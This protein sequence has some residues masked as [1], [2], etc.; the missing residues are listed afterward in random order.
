MRDSNRRVHVGRGGLHAVLLTIVAGCTSLGPPLDP[1]LPG[2]PGYRGP[3]LPE[4][5]T[6]G[7]VE[8]Q[9]GRGPVV[10]G[11]LVPTGLPERAG[12]SA[13]RTDAEPLPIGWALKRRPL[14]LD[15]RS[16]ALVGGL[17]GIFGGVRT[18]DLLGREFAYGD[19]LTSAF[20]FGALGAVSG[21]LAG[22]LGDDPRG[23]FWMLETTGALRGP[24]FRPLFRGA[25]PRPGE[26]DHQSLR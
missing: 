17:A 11:S 4:A 2:S 24:A 25:L 18:R 1:T 8:D 12:E 3:D 22:S 14:V 9:F 26:G 15:A 13:S 23:L 5:A 19:R 21:A 16:G 10:Q 7:G 6:S 20:F